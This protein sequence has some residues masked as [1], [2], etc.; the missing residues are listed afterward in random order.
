MNTTAEK[1]VVKD[2]RTEPIN[3]KSIDS[4]NGYRAPIYEVQVG[5]YKTGVIAYESPFHNC[6]IYTIGSFDTILTG[7]YT[8]HRVKEVLEAIQYS[9]DKSRLVI[10]ITNADDYTSVV[11]EIFKDNIVFKQEYENNTSSEMVM[12][13]L[14]TMA[15]GY[16][17][18]AI[19]HIDH[20]SYGEYYDE[21]DDY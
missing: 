10:D 15:I 7:V 12:Y 18:D 3:I 19:E 20:P 1:Q 21:D 14:K 2:Y 5:D 11:E 16:V 8:K 6:Q 13:M 17:E 9:M 4:G